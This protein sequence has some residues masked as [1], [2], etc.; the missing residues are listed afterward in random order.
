[1]V[2]AGHTTAVLGRTMAFAAHA[3]GVRQSRFRGQNFLNGDAV[4]PAITEVIGV[5][6]FG[7]DLAKYIE[8]PRRAL[9][10]DGRKTCKPVVGSWFPEPPWTNAEVMH[11]TVLPLHGQLQHVV[12]LLQGHVRGHQQAAPDRRG[13]AEQGGF[14]LIN[15]LRSLDLLRRHA[16]SSLSECEAPRCVRCE[17]DPSLAVWCDI[18]IAY[19]EPARAKVQASQ[20]FGYDADGFSGRTTECAKNLIILLY[21]NDYH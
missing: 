19:S 7:A 2:V 3:D 20:V 5:H 8:Q 18:E 11:V 21:E 6:R 15:F 13:G 16:M 14:E 12:Q 17:G 1:M 4:L 10:A 9:V